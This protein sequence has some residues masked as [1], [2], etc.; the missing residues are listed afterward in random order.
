MRG[1]RTAV[2]AKAGL[3]VCGKKLLTIVAATGRKYNGVPAPIDP[4]CKNVAS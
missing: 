4:L 2:K 3:K 1:M